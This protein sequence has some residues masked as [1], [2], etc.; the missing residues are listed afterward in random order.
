MV[1]TNV[2][3]ALKNFQL[4]ARVRKMSQQ[5]S[6]LQN[7]IGIAVYAVSKIKT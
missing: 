4:I 7:K 1:I 5:L 6:K 2:L 3:N